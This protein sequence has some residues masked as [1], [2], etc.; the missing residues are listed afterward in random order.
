VPT[1]EALAQVHPLCSDFQAILAPL[2]TGFDALFY[3]IEMLAD[4]HDVQ[5]SSLDSVRLLRDRYANA[6]HRVFHRATRYR[7]VRGAC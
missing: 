6:R 7:G 3:V 5:P 1:F 2:G 4:G